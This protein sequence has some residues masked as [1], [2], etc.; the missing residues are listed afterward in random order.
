MLDVGRWM[1]PDKDR[2]ISIA[3]ARPARQQ[4]VIVRHVRIRVNGDR[5]NVQFAAP[6]PLIQRLNIFQP[7]FEPVTTKIDFLLRHRIEHE[8]IIRIGGMTEG[9]DFS[10]GLRTVMHDRFRSEG[11][12]YV[13]QGADGIQNRHEDRVAQTSPPQDGFAAAN[14]SAVSRVSKPAGRFG[15][16]RCSRF[17]NLHYA[18][19]ALTKQNSR[20]AVSRVA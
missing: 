18:A 2:S 6:R 11:K 9:K 17:R 7:M 20:R 10:A 12:R 3:H 5:G 13:M 14:K 15:N 16:R 4:R 1:F 19:R 8:R